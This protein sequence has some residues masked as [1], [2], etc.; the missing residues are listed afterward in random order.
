M[1]AG[2]LVVSDWQFEVRTTL[3]GEGSDYGLEEPNVAGLG[4]A[5]KTQMVDLKHDDGAYA[6]D[7]L[8]DVRVITIPVVIEDT[9]SDAGTAFKTLV[10]TVWA[11]SSTDIPLYGQMPGYGKFYVNG[12][13]GP[14]DE[15]LSRAHFGIIRCLLTFVCPDPTITFV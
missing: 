8:D 15:D 6:G 12:R 3:I 13:P 10:Q 14:V 9:A 4:A 1:P 11:K 2:D 5:R 7:S